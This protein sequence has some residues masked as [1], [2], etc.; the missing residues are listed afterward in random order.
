M[1]N[2]TAFF[3]A[4]NE[5]RFASDCARAYSKEG[6]VLRV[7]KCAIF[8]ASEAKKAKVLAEILPDPSGEIQSFLARI[9]RLILRFDTLI[10]I[11]KVT[12]EVSNVQPPTIH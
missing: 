4:F 2:R 1:S 11:A 6:N 3:L 12:R 10:E 5:V 9:T 7:Y 8:G